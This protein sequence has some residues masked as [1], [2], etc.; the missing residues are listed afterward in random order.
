MKSPNSLDELHTVVLNKG[1]DLNIRDPEVFRLAK[2]WQRAIRRTP[3]L[4]N[5]YMSNC[6]RLA[7]ELYTDNIFL[8]N[9][10]PLG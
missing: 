4:V 1:F 6:L 10:D 5:P 2:D 9:Y 7:W 3:D 8:K